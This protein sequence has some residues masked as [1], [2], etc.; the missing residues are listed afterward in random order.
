MTGSEFKLKIEYSNKYNMILSDLKGVRYTLIRF[1]DVTID[2]KMQEQLIMLFENYVKA[3]KI[4][5]GCSILVKHNAETFVQV[6]VLC[7]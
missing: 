3:K 2:A 7:F 4:S 1:I 5:H 6:G